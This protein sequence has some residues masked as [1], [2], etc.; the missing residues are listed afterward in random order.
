MDWT[1]VYPLGLYSTIIIASM[2]YPLTITTTTFLVLVSFLKHIN[3][4]NYQPGP[5]HSYQEC[6]TSTNGRHS[7]Y[8]FVTVHPWCAIR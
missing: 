5:P 8:F 7:G 1:L 4:V 3:K 6:S 2:H